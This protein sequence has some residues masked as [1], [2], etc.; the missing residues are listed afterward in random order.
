[1]HSLLSDR[2]EN[3]TEVEVDT[4]PAGEQDLFT[5]QHTEHVTLPAMAEHGTH[6]TQCM[7]TGV[8]S[9]ISELIFSVQ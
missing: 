9:A 2:Q 1:M 7:K 6:T 5:Y 3:E 4:P 8:G